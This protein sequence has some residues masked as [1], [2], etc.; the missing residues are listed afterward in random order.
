MEYRALAELLV[1]AR[2]LAYLGEHGR[3]HRVGGLGLAANDWVLWYLRATIREIGL[4]S[5]R[6][7]GTY[8]RAVLGALDKH[9][10]SPQR[11][12]HQRNALALHRMYGVLHWIGD[13]CFKLTVAVLTVFFALYL[14]QMSWGVLVGHAFAELVASWLLWGANP[15]TFLAAL[16]PAL[17]AAVAG[18][19]ETGD[20][21]KVA[22][23]SEKTAASLEKFSEAIR[24]ARQSLT[25]DDTGDMLLATAQILTEDL[26]AW[27]SVYGHKRLE[28]T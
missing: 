24:D 15:L 25:L 3:A 27:Q 26:A 7:D 11:E 1:S 2:F 22:E 6:L 20:F 8:Q 18:I 4:P 23:R 16:L 14:F 10:V 5:A 13:S 19:R 21:D 28:L 17:G 9:V 12:W